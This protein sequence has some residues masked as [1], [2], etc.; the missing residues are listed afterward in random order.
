MLDCCHSSSGTRDDDNVPERVARVAELPHEL[1]EDMDAGF[2]S[3]ENSRSINT[4]IG[5]LERN[6]R[7]HVLLAACGSEELAYENTRLRR[8]AF[9]TAFVQTLIDAGVDKLTYTGFMD[10]LPN[11]PK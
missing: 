8:G 11:L 4:A 3:E 1:P 10:R 7:S 9:T 5:F 6:L 2:Y